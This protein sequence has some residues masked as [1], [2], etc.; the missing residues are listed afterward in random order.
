MGEIFLVVI[1]ILIALSIN[2][3]NEYKKDRKQEKELLIQLQS[4]FESNL[5]Q[6][7][8]KIALRKTMISASLNL[9]K[10]IDDSDSCQNNIALKDIV[11]STISPTFDPIVNDIV[12]SGRIQLLEDAVLKQKLSLWTSEITSVTEE[13]QLWVHYTS[14]EY[15]PFLLEQGI[16]R[17]IFHEFWSNNISKSF[18]LD[19]QAVDDFVI[20]NSKRGI[21][22]ASLLGNKKFE[23][24]VTLSASFSKLANSQSY[25]LRKRIV[26]ILE[27]INREVKK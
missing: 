25:S 17:N 1:G 26:E 2:N 9:L 19:N 7:D 11:S 22:F 16:N 4:E 3:W 6:L 8:E 12:S 13:E 5:T 15:V 23:G 14:T 27:I 21:D 18:Q 24:L 10:C 20:G